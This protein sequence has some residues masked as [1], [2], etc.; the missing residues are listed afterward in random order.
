MARAATCRLAFVL[1][2]RA[3]RRH[4]VHATRV[5]LICRTVTTVQRAS[6]R[7]AAARCRKSLRRKRQCHSLL[8][9]S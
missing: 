7:P 4:H 6:V 5:P 8:A 1:E 3:D 9:L 2:V